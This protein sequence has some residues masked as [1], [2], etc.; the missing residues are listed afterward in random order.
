MGE[1]IGDLRGG[2]LGFGWEGKRRR[3][4]GGGRRPWWGRG[5]GGGGVKV[6]FRVGDGEGEGQYGKIRN[7]GV[8]RVAVVD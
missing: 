8:G 5:S 4:G 1:Q 2:G 7:H 6:G 3:G